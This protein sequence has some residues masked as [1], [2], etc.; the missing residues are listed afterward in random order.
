[1]VMDIPT[2]K[3]FEYPTTEVQLTG[4]YFDMT[5]FLPLKKTGKTS[6]FFLYFW[7]CTGVERPKDEGPWFSDYILN[8]IYN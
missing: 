3:R 7:F 4:R 1:M 2:Y 8:L 5:D 6:A